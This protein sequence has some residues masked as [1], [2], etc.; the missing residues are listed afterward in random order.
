LSLEP[1][2]LTEGRGKCQGSGKRRVGGRGGARKAERTY[3]VLQ[4]AVEGFILSSFIH[5]MVVPKYYNQG[6]MPCCDRLSGNI[7]VT[8][9][10]TI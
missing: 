1:L 6:L 8:G 9:S 3:E 7:F 5:T 4:S 10:T 2:V